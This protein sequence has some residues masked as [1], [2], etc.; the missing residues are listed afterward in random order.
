METFGI[1]SFLLTSALISWMPFITNGQNGVTWE[2][3]RAS[4]LRGERWLIRKHRTQRFLSSKVNTDT[5]K[6]AKKSTVSQAK[7]YH[8]LN[9]AKPILE[10]PYAGNPLVRVYGG[11]GR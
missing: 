1:K 3:G 4:L 6:G 7:L 8:G 5:L 11:A 9:S 10:E 2:H